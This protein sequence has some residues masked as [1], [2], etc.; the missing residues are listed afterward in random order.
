MRQDALK[1]KTDVQKDILNQTAKDVESHPVGNYA[2]K[3][4][5]YNLAGVGAV[6]GGGAT[7]NLLFGI[8]PLLPAM[9]GGAT[10][11]GTNLLYNRPMQTLLKKAATA[12]RPEWMKQAGQALKENAP[13]G[14][15]SA[16][17]NYESTRKKPNKGNLP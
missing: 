15:L 1:G 17:E 4:A 8:N 7:A 14:A 6:T 11:A 10:I 16:V 12:E 13:L 5:T 2:E 9:L 3:R